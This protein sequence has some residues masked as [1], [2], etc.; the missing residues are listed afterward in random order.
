MTYPNSVWIRCTRIMRTVLLAIAAMGLNWSQT[1]HGAEDAHKW[2]VTLHKHGEETARAVIPA[3]KRLHEELN[4]LSKRCITDGVVDFNSYAPSVRIES[5][6]ERI[7]LRAKTIV[8]S[9]RKKAGGIW[10]QRCVRA[11]ES[12][13][14]LRQRVLD[15]VNEVH[16]R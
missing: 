16:P 13:N 7:D 14:K 10:H 6:L 5:E 4:E 3:S 11:S 8:Y 15:Y 12:D 9:T 2:L 1:S